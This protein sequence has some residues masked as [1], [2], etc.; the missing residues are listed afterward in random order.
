VGFG[1]AR[2]G[3]DARFFFGVLSLEGVAFLGVVFAGRVIGCFGCRHI[4]T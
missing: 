3:C 2:G 4:P 1:A